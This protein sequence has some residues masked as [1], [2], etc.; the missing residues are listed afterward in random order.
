L[1]F[2][3]AAKDLIGGWKDNAHILKVPKALITEETSW[4][5]LANN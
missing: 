4:N 2:N 1:H 5:S 3:L